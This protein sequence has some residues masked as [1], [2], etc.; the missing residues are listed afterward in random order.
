MWR[1]CCYLAPVDPP[2]A[3]PDPVYPQPVVLWVEKVEAEPVVR[4]VGGEADS[5]KPE[6]RESWVQLEPGHQ[7]VLQG[8]H[9]TV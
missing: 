2:V 7:V 6:S 8:S 9:V 3:H 1:M 5:E 4:A